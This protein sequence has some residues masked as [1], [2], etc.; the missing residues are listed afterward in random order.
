MTVNLPDDQDIAGGLRT[1]LPQQRWFSAKDR[2]IAAVHVILRVPLASDEGY[3]AEH[4]LISVDFTSGPTLRY[5]IP[6]GYRTHLSEPLLSWALLDDLP[7][8]ASPYD[9][10]HDPDLTGRLLTALVNGENIGP[11]RFETLPGGVL[12]SASPGR[13][14]N[15][16]QSN[17]SVVF[18]ETL[19]FKVFR[20]LE[21]GINPDV[22][23]HRALS[24][25]GCE[26]VA[27]LRGW[28]ETDIDGEPTTLAMAQQFVENAADGW[29]MALISVRDL[30]TEADL[31]AAELGSDFSGD[32]E[33]LGAALAQVHADL[34]R[35]L[36]VTERN[37][38]SSVISD[39]RGRLNAAA[40]AIPQLAELREPVLAV[41]DQAA[42][43][44]PTRV[45]RIHGDLHL[46]QVLRTPLTWLLI[47]FEGEPLKSV[48]ERR[49]P[50]SP[51]RDVAGMLRSFD[52]AG[53][54][55]LR[56]GSPGATGQREYR[57]LEWVDR[58]SSAFCDGYAAVTGED[59][60]DNSALLRAYELDKAVY[61]AVYEARHRPSWLPL[62]LHAIER[63]VAG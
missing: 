39:M 32:A 40:Q 30:F 50:D 38:E 5:Q 8:K 37:G 25:A 51:L 7:D 15:T 26:H 21:V 4:V 49:R 20:Q 17:T 2:D 24:E 29:S 14:M 62:P 11:L 46:G 61:E 34:A 19:L 13:V 45:Q 16:E 3:A 6:L 44:G 18:G 22:E 10:L 43:T 27:E 28:I 35:S 33:R 59:P 58:N 1:W 42:D 54:H 36:G 23:L 60:R 56:E 41:F 53:H 57:A 55:L 12:D 9:G 63:L 48:A 47:D 31:H 52:Y